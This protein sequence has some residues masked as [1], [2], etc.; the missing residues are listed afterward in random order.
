MLL[1]AYLILGTLLEEQRLIA[2]L[3]DQYRVYRRSVPMLIPRLGGARHRDK[4]PK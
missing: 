1:T 4:R 2:E 3:G